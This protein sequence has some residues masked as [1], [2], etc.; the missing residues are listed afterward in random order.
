[1]NIYEKLKVNIAVYDFVSIWSFGDSILNY[2]KAQVILYAIPGPPWST[3]IFETRL[4]FFQVGH[5]G[6]HLVR[7]TDNGALK[8]RFQF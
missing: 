8:F 5:D 2:L 3:Y 4:P 6:F 1:M 7:L